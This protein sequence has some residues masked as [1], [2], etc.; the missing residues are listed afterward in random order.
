VINDTRVGVNAM[1]AS[2][3]K[4]HFTATALLFELLEAHPSSNPHQAPFDFTK[5][6]ILGTKIT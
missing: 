3:C 2:A 6:R 4:K 1:N 5:N